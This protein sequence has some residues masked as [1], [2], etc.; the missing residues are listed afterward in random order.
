MKWL[1]AGIGAALMPALAQAH[2]G[3]DHATGFSSGLLHPLAGADHVLAMVAVGLV[4]ARLGGL[5]T[6]GVPLSFMVMM[7][8]GG[9]IGMAGFT[10]PWAESAI[11]LSVIVL[12]TMV[13]LGWSLPMS[14]AVVI[15]GGFAIFHGL[16]H[17]AEM[18]ETV[19]GLSYAAGFV[20]ATG[21]LHLAGIGLGY[22][23]TSRSG[24]TTRYLRL[25]TGGGGVLAGIGMLAG[26][27]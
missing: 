27:L 19:S 5:A 21:L 3:V 1:L 20:T 4:A 16:A 9:A 6:W 23:I 13:C 11:S 22:L 10:L 14:M 18:P 2:T 17:G 24:A 7:A 15:T 25:M 26:W 12:S 8:S